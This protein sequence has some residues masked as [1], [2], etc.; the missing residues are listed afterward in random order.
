MTNS[1]TY[2]FL[3]TLKERV[4]KS[5]N[6]RTLGTID[7]HV[8]IKSGSDIF[9]LKFESFSCRS[10]SIWEEDRL[11]ELDFNFEMLPEEWQGKQLSKGLDTLD[12][13]I[14]SGCSHRA[15]LQQEAAHKW[16]AAL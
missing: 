3:E 14:D 16:H 9:A 11:R 10:V 5:L 15:G 8:G 1:V 4:N 7:C 13:W 2:Q 6:F 12:V